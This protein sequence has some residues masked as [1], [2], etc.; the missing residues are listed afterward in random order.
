MRREL[1]VW[2]LAAAVGVA[3][4]G[5]L[6]HRVF[7]F[8]PKRWQV[9]RAQAID[10]ALARFGELGAPVDD[11]YVVCELD[12]DGGLERL[13][14]VRGGPDHERLARLAE[15]TLRYRITVHP[16]SAER[17]WTYRATI[18]PSGEFTSLRMNVPEDEASPDIDE[19]VARAEAERFLASIGVDR[20]RFGE[21][22]PRRVDKE[23]RTDLTLRYRCREQLLGDQT[24]Y[25]VAVTFAGSKLVGFE[26]WLDDPKE[27]DLLAEF[28]MTTLSTTFRIVVPYLLFPIV[29][30]FFLRRYHA[31]E[32]G[33]GRA[34]HVFLVT[35]VSGALMMT[36][37][38]RAATETISFGP[39]SRQLT[40]IAWGGQFVILWV[41]AVAL[42]AALSWSV[43]EATVRERQGFKLAAFDAVFHG[44]I[45]N[46]TFARSSLRGVAAAIVLTA[47]TL[48]VASVSGAQPFHSSLF[49]LWWQ[50]ASWFGIALLLYQILMGAYSELFGRLFLV[51]WA[52]G[53]LGRIGG[54]VLAAVVSG[55]LF[56]PPLFAVPITWDLGFGIFRAGIL[57]ALFLAYDLWTVLLAAIGSGVLFR[58]LPFLLS[59]H[60]ALVLQSVIP[61]VIL[62]LPV[63]V[64]VRYIGSGREFVYHYDDVPPHVR[65]IAERERQRVE[66][67]TARRI[68]SSI[69]PELPPQL[70]G[71]LLSHAYEPATEVGG[72][73]YDVLALADGRLAF[74]VGDVAGHGVSSGLVMSAAKSA[75]AVQVTFRPEVAEVFT[76]LNRMVFQ[77][78]RK[79]LLTTLCYALLDPRTRR[80]EYACAGHFSPYRLSKDG[81]VS[82]FQ[83]ISYPLG[84]R[85][86]LPVTV[87]EVQLDAGDRIIM[88]SDGIIEARRMK[89]DEPYGFDR[90]EAVLTRHAADSLMHLRDAILTD[91]R[92][93][94]GPGEQD[95]DQTLLLLEV[96]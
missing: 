10:L 48:A 30:F 6:F 22:E 15:E 62:A 67:E 92:G 85:D 68:Q 19:G 13:L 59:G 70:Q 65:R 58:L 21:P 64:S 36:M 9:N 35:L 78:A 14:Q 89:T 66:L 42:V 56:W 49:D 86:H 37:V 52:S 20:K 74:A 91:L 93:F 16:R 82:S 73:F 46:A 18:T 61:L 27:K 54:A 96:P 12:T 51:P 84:V 57:V 17:R 80:L 88:F 71:V 39:L 8:M 23:G 47:A 33:V 87:R 83:S 3:A 55:V 38:S 75:L 60:P 69:L 40:T 95:D 2:V 76:A 1:A 25:G 90:F 34:L 77:T 43:G 31:G 11:P 63:L 24:P 26:G 7:P 53:R 94:T 41:S 50:H 79:R 28:Q 29:A 5:P 4:L 45:R 44:R 81:A 72:D 32:I